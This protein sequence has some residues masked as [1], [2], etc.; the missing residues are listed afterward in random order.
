M[1]AALTVDVNDPRA[2]RLVAAQQVAAV[3]CLAQRGVQLV[4]GQD[5]TTAL[6]R[7]TADT[8][9]RVD[10]FEAFAA[11]TRGLDPAGA[12]AGEVACEVRPEP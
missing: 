8:P 11:A 10:A 1:Q 3:A 2:V 12:L 9:A 7:L 5:A 6:A 4:A